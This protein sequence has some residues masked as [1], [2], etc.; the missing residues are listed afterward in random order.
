MTVEMC[1]D[2]HICGNKFD[3]PEKC[4]EEL[5]RR[6][7]YEI[8]NGYVSKISVVA[9]DWLNQ[10]TRDDGHQQWMIQ[11]A[12][13]AKKATSHPWVKTRDALK[14]YNLRVRRENQIDMFTDELRRIDNGTLRAAVEE[15]NIE[16]LPIY[17]GKYT[18]GN[19]TLTREDLLDLV[20]THIFDRCDDDRR[21]DYYDE[22]DDGQ[23]DY[24]AGDN[25]DGDYDEW[26]DGQGEDNGQE[27]I[28]TG[29]NYHKDEDDHW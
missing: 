1:R 29:T 13:C 27:D 16:I 9:G 19:N 24:D 26:D 3:D 10:T 6:L 22:W 2:Y 17:I 18:I 20:Q 5:A 4:Q 14:A 15:H 28:P 7:I 8:H 21:G 23:G 25:V 12:Q 11:L